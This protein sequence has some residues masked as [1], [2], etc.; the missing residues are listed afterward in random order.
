MVAFQVRQ[1]EALC[2]RLHQSTLSDYSRV[3][4]YHVGNHDYF[5]GNLEY[6]LERG[7]YALLLVTC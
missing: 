2:F 4:A 1:V 3:S 7:P 5:L 6:P